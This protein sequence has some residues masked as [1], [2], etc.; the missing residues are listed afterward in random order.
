MFRTG[1]RDVIVRCQLWLGG[2]LAI[3]PC[4]SAQLIWIYS[5]KVH[6]TSTYRSYKAALHCGLRVQQL[7]SARTAHE[8]HS[9]QL[10]ESQDKVQAA[11][12]LAC[13]RQVN[14]CHV[15][16]PQRPYRRWQDF[17]SSWHSAVMISAHKRSSSTKTAAVCGAKRVFVVFAR[18]WCL[19]A[20]FAWASIDDKVIMHFL[21]LSRDP[22]IFLS[23]V[24]VTRGKKLKLKIW[25]IVHAGNTKLYT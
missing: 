8:E 3:K 13:S 6:I 1:R 10:R 18:G 21:F 4:Q 17:G 19:P 20:V 2:L 24:P 16:V 23:F 15:G 7:I 11:F 5:Y 12:E 25:D 9:S 14:G 22:A